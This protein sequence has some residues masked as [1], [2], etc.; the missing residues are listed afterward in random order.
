MKY[1]R[2]KKETRGRFH[3][4]IVVLVAMAHMI[5]SC[6]TT[7]TTSIDKWKGIPLYPEN[8]KIKVEDKQYTYKVQEEDATKIVDFYKDQMATSG[9]DDLGTGKAGI[10]NSKET[11][12]WFSRDDSY[13]SIHL[14]Q[15]NNEPIQV[16]IVIGQ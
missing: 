14:V 3:L 12:L 9:W 4:I 16:S 2:D 13:V 11:I 6:S 5:A 15:A 8:T 10:N 1:E 7:S